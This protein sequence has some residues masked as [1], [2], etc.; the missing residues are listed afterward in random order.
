MRPTRRTA[1]LVAATLLIATAAQGAGGAPTLR[2]GEPLAAALAA[3]RGHGLELIFSTALIGPDLRVDVEPGSGT[4]EEIARRILA[5]HGLT[6]VT[7]RPGL[8]S[9]V[10]SDATANGQAEQA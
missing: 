1:L 3:L 10:K 4:P 5:P 2:K 8:F 6:L 9:V 7:I